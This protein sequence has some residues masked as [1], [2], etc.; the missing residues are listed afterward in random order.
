MYKKKYFL[1]YTHTTDRSTCRI[2]KTPHRTYL[3]RHGAFTHL[4]LSGSCYCITPFNNTTGSSGSPPWELPLASSETSPERDAP[5]VHSADSAARVSESTGSVILHQ[6]AG[7]SQNLLRILRC[8]PSFHVF[9]E[10]SWLHLVVSLPHATTS[11]YC[12]FR[13]LCFPCQPIY[14]NFF[15]FSK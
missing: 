7:C 13:G 3:Y 8:P 14:R 5:V 2:Q 11:C 1:F 15:A 12:H 10:Q 6:P 9:A 4:Q